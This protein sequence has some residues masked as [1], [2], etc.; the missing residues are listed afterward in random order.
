MNVTALVQDFLLPSVALADLHNY[1]Q[2]PTAT[3]WVVTESEAEFLTRR[4]Q[5]QPAFEAGGLF[6][7]GEAAA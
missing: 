3:E 2:L 4:E 7:I 6:F 1:G 5:G